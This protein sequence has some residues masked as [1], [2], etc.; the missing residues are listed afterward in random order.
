M[1]IY[2]TENGCSY[3]DGPGADGKVNDQRRVSF[4]RALYR[5]RSGAR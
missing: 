3:G 1:P 5:A 4:L 2:V